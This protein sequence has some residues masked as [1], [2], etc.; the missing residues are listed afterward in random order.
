[1]PGPA[2]PKRSTRSRATPPFVLTPLGVDDSTGS[3]EGG[4]HREEVLQL[5]EGEELLLDQVMASCAHAGAAVRVS[6]QAH[7]PLGAF[8]HGRDQE[9]VLTVLDLQTDA[10]D[11][12]TDHR[13]SLPE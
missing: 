7:H 6:Q 11:L 4:E 13:R 12:P 3:D 1:M 8:L 2:R 10:A 5:P 9:A